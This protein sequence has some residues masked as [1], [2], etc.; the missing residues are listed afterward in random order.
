LTAIAI[1]VTAGF[2]AQ[3]R[4]ERST[5]ITLGL[6][7]ASAVVAVGAAILHFR[8]VWSGV[9][10][11]LTAIAVAVT[12]GFIAQWRT[13]RTTATT[14]EITSDRMQS[15]CREL[16]V[17]ILNHRVRAGSQ[18]DQMLGQSSAINLRTVRFELTEGQDG[19][20]KIR[21]KGNSVPFEEVVSEWDH[22]RT[23]LVITAEPGYG[24]T[25]A[26]L[27][28]LS[29]INGSGNISDGPIAELFPLAEWYRWH[30]DHARKPL[31]EW[32]AN[33]LVTSYQVTDEV[34]QTLITNDRV[35]PLLDGLDELP[36]AGQ[37]ACMEAIDAYAGRAAPFRPFVLTCRIQE[38]RDLAPHWVNT[39]QQVALIGLDG[40]QILKLLSSWAVGRPDWAVIRDGVEAGNQ[41]LLHLLRSPLRLNVV[42]QAYKERDSRELLRFKPAAAQEHIWRLLLNLESPG[43][44]GA[45]QDSVYPWLVY[46]AA[47]MKSLS[48]QQFHIHEL[49]RYAPDSAK[50]FRRFRITFGLSVGLATGLIIGLGGAFSH[51]LASGQITK[52][53]GNSLA[54]GVFFGYIFGM[55]VLQTTKEVPVARLPMALALRRTL[56]WVVVGLCG[57]AIVVIFGSNDELI[58]SQILPN[59]AANEWLR[60]ILTAIIFALALGLFALFFGSAS[61]STRPPAKLA[62]R[63]PGAI[64]AGSRDR[65]L[66]AGSGG[67]LAGALLGIGDPLNILVFGPF[68][69]LFGIL[70]GGIGTWLYHYRVRLLLTREGL[71]PWRLPDF[72]AWC[73]APKRGWLRVSDGYEFRHRDLRDYLAS[74][75]ATESLAEFGPQY[76]E[77]VAVAQRQVLADRHTDASTLPSAAESL[78]RLGPQY[79]EEAAATLLKMIADRGTGAAARQSAVESLARL[80]PQYGEDAAEVLRQVVAGRQVGASARQSAAK[81]LAGLGPQYYEEAVATLRD[82]IADRGT[83]AYARQSAAGALAGLGPQYYEEAVTTLRDVIADHSIGMFN[84]RS[85]AASLAGLGVQSKKRSD[86]Q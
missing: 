59:P 6:A 1:P 85:A 42:L 54:G 40:P 57:G 62:A 25:V 74:Q 14:T 20:P 24:K 41:T 81:V 84:R 72:L 83:G 70:L 76:R 8:G 22:G 47:K 68:G 5:A 71:T 48:T 63:G 60:G 33:Q 44:A 50:M 64:L 43:Y 21:F 58:K 30:L 10:T 19:V 53:V 51:G 9:T 65:W 4:T 55:V 23:R 66:V 75:W 2:I 11:T 17:A 3:W 32:L 67:L 52:S 61:R 16:R 86:G 35:L 26:S 13:E 28:L 39:D 18:L 38:Y 7:I 36:A 73:A 49:Y 78:A 46:L 29:H 69:A 56:P 31:T 12:A 27:T 80:G 82:V 45:R 34:A 15:W 77:H 37:L 79:H